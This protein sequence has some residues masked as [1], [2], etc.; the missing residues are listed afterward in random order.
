MPQRSTAI[1]I[2][3][4]CAESWDAMAPASGGRHCAA[5]HKTVVDFTQ[6]NDAEILAY[7]REVGAG[8][9]CGRFRAGQLGRPLQA[10][11]PIGRPSHWQLWLAGLLVAALSV[12]SCQS[13][14]KETQP[15]TSQYLPPPPPLE[16]LPPTI[17]STT[18]GDIKTLPEDS[19]VVSAA[20]RAGG[21]LT[22]MLLGRPAME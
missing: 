13:T 12:Q 7:F 14:S 15:A 18:V 3:Q 9:T 21:E 8:R 16:I 1:H 4:P 22:T 19:V 20:P 5:C 2:P 11:P 10:A 6:K 17:D